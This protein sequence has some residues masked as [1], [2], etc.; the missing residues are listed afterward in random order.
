MQF[1]KTK[2]FEGEGGPG[3]LCARRLRTARPKK[4]GSESKTLF[5]ATPEVSGGPGSR[6]KHRKGRVRD[7]R[8]GA[9][10]WQ[11]L[12]AD[13]D[14]ASS[15]TNRLLAHAVT[16][17]TA[18]QS[19]LPAVRSFLQYADAQPRRPSSLEELDALLVSYLGFLCYVK[20]AHPVQGAYTV[21]GCTY[22]MPAISRHLQLSWRALQAWQRLHIGQEGGPVGLETLALMEEHLRSRPDDHSQV[23]ADMLPVAVDGY[24]REQDLLQVQVRDIVDNPTEDRLVFLFGRAS[25][26]ESSKTGRDQGVQLD[27][28]YARSVVGRR[29]RHKQPKDKV[30]DITESR[31][32][33]LW[34]E[35]A[36]VVT[37]DHRLVGPPHSLRHTGASRDRATGRRTIEEIMERGRWKVMASVARYAKIHA[38]VEACEN[39]S[40]EIKAAGGRILD[41]RRA[42]VIGRRM[43]SAPDPSLVEPSPP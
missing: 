39:Q 6:S 21:N 30:F 4:T 16:D 12:A 18:L 10:A 42:S 9:H 20:D 31:F 34:K 15:C 23:A 43:R 41:L 35:A 29:I 37:G 33:Q 11:A 19:Y 36:N 28:P 17:R 14:R 1:D 27:D 7:Q 3:A 32:R 8:R 26:G 2:G 40:P 25:R 5:L 24:M 38:W 13:A 22:L